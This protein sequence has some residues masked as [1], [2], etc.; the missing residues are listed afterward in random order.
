MYSLHGWGVWSALR[1]PSPFQGRQEGP[2]GSPNTDWKREET[3]IRFNGINLWLQIN[4]ILVYKTNIF[5]WTCYLFSAVLYI[6]NKYFFRGYTLLAVKMLEFFYF[7]I[8]AADVSCSEFQACSYKSLT[9]SS[10]VGKLTQC[11]TPVET[12]MIADSTES[13]THGSSLA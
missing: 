3:S 12:A 1:C 4:S 7:S 11:C 2:W 10:S 5:N 9:S 8:I 6:A 13:H